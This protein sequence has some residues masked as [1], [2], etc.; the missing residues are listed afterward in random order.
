MIRFRFELAPVDE[1]QPW[2]VDRHLHWFALTE[3]W[4]CP[5]VGGIELLRY[6][7]QTIAG[8][9]AEAPRTGPPWADYYVVRLWEDLLQALPHILEPVPHDLVDF[10]AAGSSRR[11]DLGETELPDTASVDAAV[12]AYC[13]RL[14]DTGYLRFGPWL[15][16]WRTTDP[17]DTVTLYWHFP[18]D[19]EGEI[20]FT[21]PLSG[22]TSVTTDEFVAAVQDLDRSLFE[23]MQERVDGI[24]ATGPPT[25][26]SVDLPG[27]YREHADRR[28][29]LSRALAREVRT[30]WDAVRS[31]ASVLLPRSG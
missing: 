2:G 21:A 27:L 30:D 12:A 26:A 15:Q 5:E 1:V 31:G 22:R 14:V 3:G 16:W 29:R 7:E 13:D 17:V 25:G 20:G 19:P 11:R 23:A 9:S 28:T 24:V 8:L 18:T 10:I 6:T 4:Y